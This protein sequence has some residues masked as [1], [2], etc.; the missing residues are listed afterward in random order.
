M[1]ILYFDLPAD[2][3]TMKFNPADS[4]ET[5]SAAPNAAMKTAAQNEAASCELEDP[6]PSFTICT[7]VKDT[8]V[9]IVTADFP[10]E[11]VFDVANGSRLG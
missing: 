4:A 3:G 11:Q 8:G 1:S 10:A 9:F 5:S 7:V 2:S 6:V